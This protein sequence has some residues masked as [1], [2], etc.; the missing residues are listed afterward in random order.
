MSSFNETCYIGEGEVDCSLY[1][2]EFSAKDG[3]MTAIFWDNLSFPALFI[4][5]LLMCTVCLV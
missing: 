1:D 2:N 3:H 5:L 4:S